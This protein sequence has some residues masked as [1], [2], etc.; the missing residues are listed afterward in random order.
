[1]PGRRDRDSRGPLKLLKG[2]KMP[3]MKTKSS[4]KK[5]FRVTASGKIKM[6]PARKRHGMSKRPH[7]MVRTARGSEIMNERDAKIVRT[8]MPY[9]L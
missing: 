6:G 5:R 7:K 2:K 1:M 4:A 8:H 9:D 3:K